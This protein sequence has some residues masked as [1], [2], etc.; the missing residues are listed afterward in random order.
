VDD[1]LI[2]PASVVGGDDVGLAVLDEAQVAKDALIEDA[3]DA[4]AVVVGPLG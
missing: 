3:I 4:L 2:P 1:E